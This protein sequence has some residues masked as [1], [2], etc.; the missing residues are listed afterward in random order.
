MVSRPYKC[1]LCHSA[2]RNES[3]MKWHISHRHEIPA[4]FDALGKDYKA[5]ITNLNQEIVLKNKKAEQLEKELQETQIALMREKAEKIAAN[6]K[7]AEL[8][9]AI[10][11]MM[12]MIAVRDILIKER[13]NIELPNPFK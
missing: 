13:L 1:P 10:Q 5:E 3:G 6:A 12:M 8:E 9:N 11:K 4:A 7:I 2:F